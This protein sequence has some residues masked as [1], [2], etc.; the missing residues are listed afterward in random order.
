MT[1]VLYNM[2]QRL[3]ATCHTEFTRSMHILPIRMVP[4]LN[5]IQN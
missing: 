4:D 2:A 3:L 5:T 1:T